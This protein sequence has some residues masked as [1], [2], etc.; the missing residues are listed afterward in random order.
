MPDSYFLLDVLNQND[1]Q[2]KSLQKEDENYEE[3]LDDFFD[4]VMIESDE[5]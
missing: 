5:V 3:N 2:V 1:V 4:F